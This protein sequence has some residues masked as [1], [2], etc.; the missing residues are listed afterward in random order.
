MRRKDFFCS[1][2]ILL[3]SG[4]LFQINFIYGQNSN[5]I[6]LTTAKFSIGNNAAWAQPAFN[7]SSWNDCKL[8]DTWQTQGFADYH[9]F[10]WYRI[11]VN[12]PSAL[13]NKAVWQDSLRIFLA[14]VNDADETFLNGVL[15]GKTGAFPEDKGG[16]V[17]KWPAVRNYCL[18][19]NNPAIFWDKENVIAVKVYD[20]G[21]S[22]GIFMGTPFVDMLEKFDG[23]DFKL[24]DINFNS[25]P[26]TER[27]LSI[28]NKFNTT[29]SGVFH[30]RVTDEVNG[31]IIEQRSIPVS[32]APFSVHDCSFYFP[33][34]EGIK[35]LY[36]FKENPSGKVKSF[37]ETAPYILTPQEKL[38]PV[39]N[40]PDVV[41]LHP[42]SPFIFRIPVSGKRPFKFTLK[43]LPPG[44][45]A[46]LHQGIITGMVKQ[47]GNYI[48]KIFVKNSHGADSKSIAIKVGDR[49]A[50]TPP[51]GWNSW[52]C[53]GLG[54]S[55]DR[56]KS[57]ANALIEK[58]LADYG[59]NYI[60]VDD[61]WQAKNRLA[62]GE[63]L[64]N[65]K[66]TDMKALGD[67][68]HKEGLRFGIYSS[69]GNSTCGGFL[70]SLGHERQDA[71]TYFKWGV[72]YLKYDLCS[73]SDNVAGDTTLLAQQKPYMVMRDALKQQQR[74]IIYSICQYG[75]HDVW[76]WGDAMNGNLWRTTED[77]TDTWESL[78][79]IGFSQTNNAAYAHPG[80][81][82]DPDMLI[83]G[84]V[85]WGEGL[86][87]SNLTPHEQYTHISLWSLL[88]APLLIG[89]DISK[90]DDFTLNLLKNREVIAIDQDV[91][92]SQAI[93]IKN[94]DQIQ[95]WQKKL[96]AGGRA[97][98][99]FNLS[100]AYK[101]YRF[102]IPNARN[103]SYQIR[104]VWAQKNIPNKSGTVVFQIP[105]HGVKLIK[106]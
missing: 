28:T 74:D 61:G 39:I 45:H 94:R 91:L 27:K 19:V 13:K 90:L 1:L 96:H 20:G 76:K 22:G 63:I 104:D 89:C 82:N 88:S 42:G 100:N 24:S 7:D 87:P 83:V 62:S 101:T 38:H 9:G 59:W 66:F 58:G 54:V 95:V 77:I 85:G 3:L 93:R 31:K 10:A 23:I 33:H 6:P 80:G 52:N 51:M 70:G 55:Y 69:P 75:I 65:E 84:R 15:I 60:N 57:S 71:N 92:G 36:D 37:A 30:Y 34:R 8:G 68:L 32:L 40:A 53:W 11:H 105:P 86:H 47:K 99:I 14:H 43:N 106:I 21:G 41:G 35:L 97:I 18:A 56:V 78:Y 4:L 2:R 44:L 12:I 46:D 49:L 79:N 16:Y 72:D 64:P 73:Y 26:R 50:L 103:K 98:G 29:V 25:S 17:S 81:W 48:A 5:F 102:T 67:E